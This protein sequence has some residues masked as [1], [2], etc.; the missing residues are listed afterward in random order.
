M[1]LMYHSVE[2]YTA[3]PY[4]VTVSPER[5]DAQMRWLRRRGLRGTSM[6]EL[7][8]AVREGNAKGLVGLTFDDGYADFVEHVLPTLDRYGFT[9]T[10]FV[11]AGALGGT[12]TWDEPGPRKALMTADEV[13]AVAATGIEVGSH[14]LSHPRLPDTDALALADEVALSRSILRQLLGDDVDGFCYP[15][16][17]VGQREVDAV[18]AAGYSYAC[19]VGDGVRAGQYAIPRTFVGDRDG[20]PR[21]YAKWAR[22]RV[23]AARRSP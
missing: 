4:Q 14:S 23:A 15:Y 16:G 21:L 5:F 3:D 13:R 19:A 10:V 6:R 22:H 20:S 7:L 9:A 18:R 12:N 11:I 2:P 1:V 8:L 17:G